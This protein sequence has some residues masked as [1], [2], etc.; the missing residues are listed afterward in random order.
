MIKGGSVTTALAVVRLMRSRASA[1]ACIQ[2]ANR[3]MLQQ[4]NERYLAMIVPLQR[5]L[6]RSVR[7]YRARRDERDARVGYDTIEMAIAAGVIKRRTGGTR[8]RC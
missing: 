2:S 8:A 1:A 4:R 7:A 3:R 5:L 6:R